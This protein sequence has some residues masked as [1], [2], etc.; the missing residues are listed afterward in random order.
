MEIDKLLMAV[1]LS[2]LAPNPSMVQRK[3]EKPK[4]G[5]KIGN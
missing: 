5:E 3:K 2:C 4:S 1:I